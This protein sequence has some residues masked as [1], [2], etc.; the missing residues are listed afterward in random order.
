MSCPRLVAKCLKDWNISKG[1]SFVR[2]RLARLEKEWP[3]PLSLTVVQQKALLFLHE[4]D[5][6]TRPVY[7]KALVA[8]KLGGGGIGEV[9]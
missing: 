8:P 2:E 1:G 5:A 6:D 4:L 3:G 7:F 9:V